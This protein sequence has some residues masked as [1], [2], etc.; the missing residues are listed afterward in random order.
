MNALKILTTALQIRLSFA[1]SNI[2]DKKYVY[3]FE[4]GSSRI[5]HPMR[6]MSDGTDRILITPNLLA[7]ADH[8][9]G[10]LNNAFSDNVD[11]YYS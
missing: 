9:N 2:S 7:I 4:V 3:S 8:G 11:P 5:V 6:T 10:Q 1:V